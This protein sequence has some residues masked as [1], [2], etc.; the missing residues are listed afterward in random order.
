MAENAGA[1]R[2]RPVR[3][4]SVLRSSSRG[5]RVSRS[6][7]R[8]GAP[9]ATGAS[10][11]MRTSIRLWVL[12]TASISISRA[13][14]ETPSKSARRASG[15]VSARSLSSSWAL[16]TNARPLARASSSASRAERLTDWAFS[17][18]CAIPRGSCPSSWPNQASACGLM[19]KKRAP[20]ARSRP[21]T[22]QAWRKR[23]TLSPGASRATSRI[24]E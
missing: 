23:S 18:S 7:Q 22:P 8:A 19:R 1:E 4:E 11:R 24:S 14:R 5:P 20:A 16:A 21:T 2:S 17:T 3:A 13:V 10:P 15:A 9:L 6:T 12:R